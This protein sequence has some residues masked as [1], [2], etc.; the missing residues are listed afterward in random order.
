[1]RQ[2]VKE[3]IPT[4]RL[5]IRRA[6]KE[7]FLQLRFVEGKARRK[8]HRNLKEMT[9][10]DRSALDLELKEK[11]KEIFRRIAFGRGEDSS[12]PAKKSISM[13]LAVWIQLSIS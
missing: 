10:I 12:K 5:R 1:L 8:H 3:L 9:I 4:I 2:R 11:S 7:G 6:Q 13:K